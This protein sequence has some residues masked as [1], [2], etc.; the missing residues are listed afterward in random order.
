MNI[1]LGPIINDS[2]CVSVFQV[3]FARFLEIFVSFLSGH[4]RSSLLLLPHVAGWLL[5]LGRGHG[6]AIFSLFFHDCIT[7]SILRLYFSGFPLC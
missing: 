4:L 2:V 6:V 3:A 1:H 7:G 5:T